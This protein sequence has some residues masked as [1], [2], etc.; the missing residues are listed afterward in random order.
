MGAGEEICT[1]IYDRQMTVVFYL[2]ETETHHI[3]LQDKV[4]VIPFATTD[5]IA[6]A[7]TEINPVVDEN[8]MVEVKA[9]IINK[10]NLLDGM[11]V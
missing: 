3:K 8:G 2:V 1:I 4:N 7:V 11:Q 5:T 9:K 10:N 6:G